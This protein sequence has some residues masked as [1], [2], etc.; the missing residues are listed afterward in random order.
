[1]VN[2]YNKEYR[3]LPMNFVNLP[4]IF[5]SNDHEN[6]HDFEFDR[7]VIVEDRDKTQ[8]PKKYKVLLHN[9][10]YTT[11]EFVIQILELFFN[12]T[13][14]EA[15]RIMLK[16]HN[17]GVG[18]CGVYTYEVAESKASQVI[19]YAREHEHPLKCSIEPESEK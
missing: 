12:K 2:P 13:E 15:K 14:E 16:V 5:C 18:I 7:D 4:D 11:M 6:D 3:I 8:L 1:M 19:R 17:E 9:D 10:D